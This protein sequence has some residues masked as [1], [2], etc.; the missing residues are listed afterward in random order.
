M[1]LGRL[2]D[3]FIHPA[4]FENAS[5]LRRARLLVRASL[6]TSIFSTSYVALSVIFDYE[7]GVYFT[8]FNVIGYFALPFLVRTRISLVLLGFLYNAMGAITVL[9]LTWF[10]GGMWSAIYPWIIAIPLLALLIVG[11]KAAI[12]WTL[13]SLV[14]MVAFG[15]ME[16]KGIS[17][18]VEYNLELKSIWYLSILPGLLLIIMV[19]SFTFEHTMQRALEDIEAQNVTIEKQSAELAKLIEEKDDIIR[20]LA[21]DLKNPLVNITVLT[22]LLEREITGPDTRNLVEMIASASSNAQ[23]LVKHVLEMAT[24]ESLEGGVKLVPTDFQTVINEVVQSFKQTAESKGIPIKTVDLNTS[25]E[26]IANLTYLRLVLENLISNAIKFST[27]GKEIH[28]VVAETNQQVQI[29]VR[30][31]GP[32]VPVEEE[33]RLFKKFSRLS[34][35]P[36]GGES[37]SGLGLSLVKR[38]MEVMKGNVWF[39]RPEGGGSVFAIELSKA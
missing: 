19:V 23:V 8:A 36:T 31:H 33:N 9:V 22:N 32:G 35:R 14:W 13:F 38:Y 27:S 4:Y 21:H 1:E 28:V 6:L 37:S 17:F 26:A 3:W 30:D 11:K 2:A 5:E 7:R 39:E 16:L 10:S 15:V 29:R 12:Y 24:L 25:C 34:V 20:I 18:P